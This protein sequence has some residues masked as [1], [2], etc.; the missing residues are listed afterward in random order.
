MAL[1]NL[2]Q[3]FLVAVVAV[4]ILLVVLYMHRAEPTWALIFA[5]SLLAM[6]E[7]FG[8]TLPKEDRG[9]AL[10]LGALAVAAFYWCGAL[11][12]FFEYGHARIPFRV[13]FPAMES[14]GL[15]AAFHGLFGL[16]R[17]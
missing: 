12:I 5:A 17:K 2:A 8:M 10:V 16:R 11:T 13:E 14:G 7:F 4:P 9:A 3:R 1:G 6:R 15:V